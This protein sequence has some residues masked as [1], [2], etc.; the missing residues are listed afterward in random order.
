MKLIIQNKQQYN[1]LFVKDY[2]PKY[3]LSQVNT[4]FS[5]IKCKHLSKYLDINILNLFRFAINNL[6]ISEVG[7]NYILSINKSLRYKKYNLGK[8][9]NFITY[10]NRDIKGY[11]L[12]DI[13]FKSIEENIGILY[14]RW[15]KGWQ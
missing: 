4:L 12:L 7:D 15:L 14:E 3:I 1:E 9:I 2:L 5:N 13:I 6:E 8:L 11:R 10:G